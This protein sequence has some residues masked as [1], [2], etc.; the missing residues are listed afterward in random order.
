MWDELDGF[1][2]QAI[3]T[4]KACLSV[5]IVICPSSIVKG[6]KISKETLLR[7]LNSVH[8]LFFFHF[9][10]DYFNSSKLEA[11]KSRSQIS[12]FIKLYKYLHDAQ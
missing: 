6:L 8:F 7:D 11:L 12:G 2:L 10:V 4:M 3:D 5:N 1:D 9:G